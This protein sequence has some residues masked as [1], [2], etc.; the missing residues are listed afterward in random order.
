[1][2]DSGGSKETNEETVPKEVF[3]KMQKD[4]HEYKNKMKTLQDERDAFK[5]DQEQ[6]ETQA[7]KEQEKWKDLYAQSEKK[8]QALNDRLKS[9]T[10]KFVSSHKLNAVLSQVGGFKKTEYNRFVETS[11]ILV[12]EDGSIEE[13]TLKAEIERVKKEYPELLKVSTGKQELDSKAAKTQTAEKDLS[14]MSKAEISEY[15]RKLLGG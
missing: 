15:R 13:G 11:K 12:N 14:K 8:I 9:E 1:M 10:E 3:L 6:R 4:M 7:L 2:S 5:A